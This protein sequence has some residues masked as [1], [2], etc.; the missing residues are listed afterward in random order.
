MSSV[1]KIFLGALV[2]LAMIPLALPCLCT[3]FCC[4]SIAMVS[5]EAQ[6]QHF[7]HSGGP[8]N[9]LVMGGI[10]IIDSG[11]LIAKTNEAP[12]RCCS[13][14]INSDEKQTMVVYRSTQNRTKLVREIR[15]ILQVGST[16]SSSNSVSFRCLVSA[17]AAS[18]PTSAESCI[19][20]C[21]LLL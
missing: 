21:R 16:L 19:L 2:K 15:N 3:A 4:C 10:H 9:M 8:Q 11:G 1:R 18:C 13:C 7:A 12:R 17:W 20:F 14:P 6:E 5:C